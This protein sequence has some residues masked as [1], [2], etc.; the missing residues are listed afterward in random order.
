MACTDER[1]ENDQKIMKMLEK[2]NIQ[3]S[4]LEMTVFLETEICQTPLPIQNY[5]LIRNINNSLKEKTE[6]GKKK[7][8]FRG[9]K[10]EEKVWSI[11]KEVFMN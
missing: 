2:L 9:I 6:D 7:E 10:E 4:L 11:Y 8:L 5:L 3:I 1:Y